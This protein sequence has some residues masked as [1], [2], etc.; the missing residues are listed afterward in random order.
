MTAK[1]ADKSHSCTCSGGG[2]CPRQYYA[3]WGRL[4]IM[5]YSAGMDAFKAGNYQAAADAFHDA[6]TTDDQDHKAWNALGV[7]YTKTGEYEAADTCYENALTLAPGTPAYER[8]RQKNRDRWH[9]DVLDVDDGPVLAIPQQSHPKP[10]TMP[11]AVARPWW[12]YAA[13]FIVFIMLIAFVAG[14]AGGSGKST[15]Y[16]APQV[17]AAPVQVTAAP[18]VEKTP[19]ITPGQKNAVRKAKSY[20]MVMH[21]S[22]DGLVKQLEEFEK[23]SHSD[24]VYGADNSGADWN[25]QAAGKAQDYLDV[26]P[27]SRDGL[28]KQLVEFEKFTPEQAEHGASAV[29]Y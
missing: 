1:V 17:T 11:A 7:V 26:M 21:F 22:R 20:L 3:G 12:H 23:F 19:A 25:E 15:T 16:Q 4:S 2:G 5:S 18:V 6:I 24:A 27:F 29:G 8:N 13:G 28:I 9:P 10:V 14:M